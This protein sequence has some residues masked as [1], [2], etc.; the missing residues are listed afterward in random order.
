MKSREIYVVS[1]LS[2]LLAVAGFATSAMA[3]G[4]PPGQAPT[5]ATTQMVLKAKA[6]VSGE[7]LKV[8]LPRPQ[9]ADLANGLHLIVLE[10]RRLPQIS[11]QII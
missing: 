6:P 1:N 7:V 4:G 10:D 2:L 8:K 9:E 3:Q 11:F 5:P